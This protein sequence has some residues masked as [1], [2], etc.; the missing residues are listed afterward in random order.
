MLDL[1]IILLYVLF[2]IKILLSFFSWVETRFN[3]YGKT[4]TSS[5]ASAA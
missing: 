1:L 2:A 4:V 5:E 3:I